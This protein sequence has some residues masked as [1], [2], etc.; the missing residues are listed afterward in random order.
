[1]AFELIQNNFVA[2]AI[3]S[4]LILFVVTNNNF[5]KKTNRLFLLAASCVLILI[6]EEAWEAQLA[7]GSTYSKLRVLLSAIG[8]SLRPL[9]PYLLVM[10]IRGK[11]KKTSYLLSLPLLLNTLVAFSSLFCD[12]S[13]SY[14]Q[15]NEFVR[16]PLGYLPFLTAGFYVCV[17]LLNTMRDRRKG[18]FVEALIVSAIVLL[19]FISTVME[20]V[21]SFQFIQNPSIATS[22]TF[23][24]LFLHSNQNNRDPLT[25]ALTRRRFYLDAEKFNTSISAIIS[26]DINNL[27]QLNDEYGHMEGDK[28][29][30]T[31]TKTIKEYTGMRVSL[32]RT[33]G[34]EFM[35]LCYGMEEK[36]VQKLIEDIQ[37]DLK[38]TAYECAIGYAMYSVEASFSLACQL[39]DNVMYENKRKMKSEKQIN[40]EKK[41]D[42][43]YIG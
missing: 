22:I 1:M 43:Q 3:T 32:Y 34:D 15:S 19:A 9:V 30:I 13:F 8:Y 2:V 17:L 26:L 12:I 5:D 10:I 4:F 31:V 40:M 24:Y 37:A 7:L 20:S 25:G 18:G 23:Y 41:R 42:T 27:K 29:L 6:I 33:G 38:Q 21:F 35:I 16:G 11:R 39:A 14:T 36:Q 28:A